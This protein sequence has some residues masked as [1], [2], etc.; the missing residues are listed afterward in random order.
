[1]VHRWHL[2]VET[3]APA[4][5]LRTQGPFMNWVVVN[6]RL[7]P[8]PVTPRGRR[9]VT[10]PTDMTYDFS[11]VTIRAAV[12]RPEDP[13][14]KHALGVAT[15]GMAVDR[16]V[17]QLEAATAADVRERARWYAALVDRRADASR[18]DAAIA[19]SERL[20]AMAPAPLAASAR[21]QRA[22]L[23]R[24]AGDPERAMA[25][26]VAAGSSSEELAELAARDDRLFA[27]SQDDRHG[28]AALSGY[29]AIAASGG[30]PA[31]G[32]A[33][34]I[35]DLERRLA[36]PRGAGSLDKAAIRAAFVERVPAFTACY[37]QVLEREPTTR[38]TITIK[39]TV[40]N[41]G[42][43]L[44]HEVSPMPGPRGLSAVSAC[45]DGVAAT[46]VFPRMRWSP[47][48]VIYFPLVLQ[49]GL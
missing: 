8:Y 28:R 3:R 27:R 36:G 37:R 20:L 30:A 48:A 15:T 32:V 24:L 21:G 42:R 43:L 18:V 34:L 9:P 7:V 19:G 40:G 2:R 10:M 22:R 45:V 39:A 14:I 13:A 16:A 4:V 25:E 49:P 17:A 6:G 23:A 47:T 46:A 29:R 44:A 5:T 38:G 12:E 33:A 1:V 41:D 11:G 26:A 35:A 31:H